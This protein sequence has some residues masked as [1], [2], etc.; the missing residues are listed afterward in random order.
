M[1]RL[2]G[3]RI[4]LPASAPEGWADKV[5]LTGVA[6]I[7][8]AD[9]GQLSFVTNPEYAKYAPLCKASAIIVAEPVE[10]V[11]GAQLI[12]KN[13]YWAFARAAQVFYREDHGEKGVH[14]QA[15]IDPTAR[16]GRDVTIHP[17][18]VVGKN[19]V[20]GDRVVLYPGVFVGM[21][22]EV[23]E[24]SVLRANVVIEHGCRVGKR[25]IIH[26]CTVVG[27]D[28]F[29]FA[30]GESGV[31]K[32]PQTGI[33]V[34]GDDVELGAHVSI[35]RAAMGETR[36]GNGCKLD[37]KVHV[38]HNVIVGEHCMFS[39]QSGIAGSAKIGDRVVMG[40]HGAINGH[41][42]VCSDVQLGG[43]SA[44]SKTISEGGQYM[45][46]PALPAGEWRRKEVMTRRLP[47]MEKRLREI[48]KQLRE[49]KEASK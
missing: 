22:A 24:D 6:P 14:A 36:L 41:I 17:F 18:V 42:T 16:V 25:A 12:H 37:D 30:P 38:A 15:V 39:G 47:D 5:E 1:A 44:I 29:G 23:G 48:E 3:A 28:G 7:E 10:G 34:I 43:M 40:G 9:E 49:L 32:I 19:A 31:A 4:H 26:A 27:A 33:V 8:R 13:P 2:L 35:D 45:G 11:R 46:I 20:I 21:N